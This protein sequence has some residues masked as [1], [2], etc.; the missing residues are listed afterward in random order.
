METTIKTRKLKFPSYL[1]TSF[2]GLLFILD[3]VTTTM[4]MT[5]AMV[6]R[7]AKESGRRDI[8]IIELCVCFL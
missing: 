2:Y 5:M 3:V 7:C 8:I 1:L 4:M 6:A